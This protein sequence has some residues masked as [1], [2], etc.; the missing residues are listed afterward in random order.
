MAD[1]L[2]VAVVFGGL[3]AEHEVSCVSARSAVSSSHRASRCTDVW[4]RLQ[5]ADCASWCITSCEY[6]ISNP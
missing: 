5:I 2:R 6:A 1:R 4:N 3:S